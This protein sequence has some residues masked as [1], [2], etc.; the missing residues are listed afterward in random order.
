M[1]RAPSVSVIL[2]AFNEA[3]TLEQVVRGVHHVLEGWA[4][5]GEILI[6][7]DG[8]TDATATIADRVAQE[9]PN[10]RALHHR[11]NAGYGAAQRTGIASAA[12][13]LVSVF[14]ADGQVPP[15]ELR[16]YLAAAHSADVI[17]GVYSARPDAIGRRLFSRAYVFVLWMLFGLR[18]R[19]INAPK[20]FRLRHL[21]EIEVRSR[22]GFADAEIVIQLHARRRT[23][24]EIDVACVPRT[25]GRSSVG[26]KAAI[27]ALGEL[28]R[29]W[30][31]GR[32]RVSG[33]PA[34]AD[35]EARS[36]ADARPTAPPR[37]RSR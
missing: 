21:G 1:T 13:E 19:N 6:V 11:E 29:F 35:A 9:L 4:G 30:L 33:R 15:E 25:S 28:W 16:R 20:L 14:P 36:S 27:Q 8:S 22:G 2:P 3:G 23:F 12:S 24:A 18:L 10:V 34:E 17:A 32:H 31:S 26:S 7:D 5:G 37:T